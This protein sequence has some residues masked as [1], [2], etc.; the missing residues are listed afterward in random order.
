[1]ADAKH[2]NCLIKKKLSAG[3]FNWIN[4]E[5]FHRINL[6]E[7]DECWTLFIHSPSAQSWGFLEKD[8]QRYAFHDHDQIVHQPSN[9]G[10]WKT[11]CRPVDKP[12]MRKPANA[13]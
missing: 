9:P 10:W 6:A 7:N 8:Q 13:F 11:A 1:M 2:E 4:G 5:I 3:A 12:D